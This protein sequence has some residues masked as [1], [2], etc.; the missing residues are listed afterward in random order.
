MTNSRLAFPRV[1]AR[2]TVRT[3][4]QLVLIKEHLG[5]GGGLDNPMSWDRIVEKFHWL[6]EAFADEDLRSRL[7]QVVQPLDAGP[8]L[9]PMDFLAQVRPT[10]AF[11]TN[12]PGIQ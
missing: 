3:K 7:I 1:H 10:K 2:I 11:P 9:D 5:Y 12:Q 8:L 6:S 4:D